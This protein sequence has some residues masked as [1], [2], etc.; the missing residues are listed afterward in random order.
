MAAAASFPGYPKRGITFLRQIARS[1]NRD[2]YQERK[3]IFESDVRGATSELIEALNDRLEKF[4][5]EYIA[6]SSAVTARLT[7][8]AFS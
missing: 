2:W 6:D 4:A 7:R 3:A 5:P 8:L 1:N